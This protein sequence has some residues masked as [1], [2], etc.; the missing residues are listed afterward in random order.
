MEK[1]ILASGNQGK[2]L[3]IQQFFQ[4]TGQ[5]IELIPQTQLGIE[6][7]PETGLTFIENALIK[8]RHACQ[9]TGLPALA[10]D[11]GVVVDALN[12]A[13]GIYTARYAGGD[14]VDMQANIA[15]LLTALTGVEQRQARFHCVI[16]LLRHV[17]DPLPL[18][19]Q[20]TWEGTILQ[21]PQGEGGFGYDPLF[22]VPTHNC[23]AAQ[24]DPGEKNR[25]S[26]RGQA[27]AQLMAFLAT[28]PVILK[29]ALTA[30]I[31]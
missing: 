12:G 31:D 5:M 6:D 4:Q 14:K 11:S 10:D 26:H 3:E 20:G 25:I 24:L 23:S 15:K 17:H 21:Q 30:A 22:L 18:I 9:V 7:V 2:I 19:C 16:V 1:I 13:P 28:A 29:S 27:L 8:A